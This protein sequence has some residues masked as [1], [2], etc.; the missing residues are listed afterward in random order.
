VFTMKDHAFPKFCLR[1]YVWLLYILASRGVNSLMCFALLLLL[2]GSGM[3]SQD[4]I[5]NG[6]AVCFVLEVDD[7]VPRA[8]L[9]GTD[10]REISKYFSRRVMDADF[11]VDLQTV[12]YHAFAKFA[13]VYTAMAWVFH[14]ITDVRG[15]GHN[16]DCMMMVYFVLYQGVILI[17]IWSPSIVSPLVEPLAM[18]TVVKSPNS[19]SRRLH[20]C[21]GVFTTGLRTRA[22]ELAKEVHQLSTTLAPLRPNISWIQLQP[23]VDAGLL[24][25][26]EKFGLAMY[27]RHQ[28]QQFWMSFICAM[29]ILFLISL[30]D[31]MHWH[32]EISPRR[33]FLDTYAYHLSDI[34]GTCGRPHDDEMRWGCVRWGS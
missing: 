9:K 12:P 27:L 25:K 4:V 19:V 22:G 20:T 28:L 14:A 8:F 34:L 17:S 13:M 26:W 30:A 16:M 21:M 29:F 1:A 15:F 2:A 3:K 31:E 7:L 32:Y 6:L 10:L 18:C 33:N 11:F 24:R 5:L 23:A